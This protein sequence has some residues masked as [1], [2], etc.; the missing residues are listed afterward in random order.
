MT[1]ESRRPLGYSLLGGAQG[2]APPE[3]HA[4]PEHRRKRDYQVHRPHHLV[5][6]VGRGTGDQVRDDH[7]HPRQAQSKRQGHEEASRQAHR[8]VGG[9]TSGYRV[10]I[11][12]E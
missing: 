6:A 4:S 10:G 11:G 12:A 9:E 2:L 3:P 5:D 1:A 8:R 7:H